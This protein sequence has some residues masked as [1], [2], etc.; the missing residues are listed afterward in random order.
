MRRMLAVVR[1]PRALHER[2]KRH[3]L[4]TTTV[5]S[6]AAARERARLL[7]AREQRVAVAASPAATTTRGWVDVRVADDVAALVCDEAVVARSVPALPR[8]TV[9]LLRSPERCAAA[10]VEQLEHLLDVVRRRVANVRHGATV[11]G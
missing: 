1:E 2:M 6:I 5:A 9:R 3:V 8:R 10:R 7:D 11:L 4:G